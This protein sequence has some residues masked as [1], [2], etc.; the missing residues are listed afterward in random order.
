MLDKF[1]EIPLYFQLKRIFLDRIRKRIYKINEAIPSELEIQKQFNVSRITVRRAIAELEREGYLNR[2]PGKGT[3][4]TK[5]RIEKVTQELNDISSWTETLKGIGVKPGTVRK[6]IVQ[7][8]P[9]KEIAIALNLRPNEKVTKIKRWRTGNNVPFCIM[10]N[11]ILSHIVPNIDKIAWKC[12]SLYKILEEKYNIKFGVARETVEARA[13][14]K[15]ESEFFKINLGSPVLVITRKTCNAS[16]TPFEIVKSS[17]H[18]D[19]YKYVVTLK[20]RPKIKRNK[21]FS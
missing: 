6:E 19:L 1:S 12:E 10:T 7:I 9:P 3:F 14:S 11:Y 15:E 17:N 18:A 2:K 13:A 20:G 16:G 5:Y 21:E 4:V 8:I